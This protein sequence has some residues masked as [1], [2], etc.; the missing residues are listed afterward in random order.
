MKTCIFWTFL[1]LSLLFWSPRASAD[2]TEAGPWSTTS[3]LR[4]V[5]RMTLFAGKL[6]AATPQGGLLLIDP[7]SGAISRFNSGDGLSSDAISDLAVSPSGEL[8]LATGGEGISPAGLCSLDAGFGVRTVAQNLASL[9][10]T[11][12]AADGDFVYYGTRMDGAGRLSSGV[13]EAIYTSAGEGLA[14]DRVLYA[15]A[16]GGEAWFA[17]QGG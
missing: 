5:R 10:V 14:D 13:P 15:A 17:T 8:W 11:A 9:E 6:I 12:V 2:L 7:T 3:Q 1:L 16:Y 4:E